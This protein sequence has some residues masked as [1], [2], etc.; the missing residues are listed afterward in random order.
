MHSRRQDRWRHSRDARLGRLQSD[1]IF[2]RVHA[3]IGRFVTRCCEQRQWRENTVRR[4]LHRWKY[5]INSKR[6]HHH[7]FEYVVRLLFLS[8]WYTWAR[9]H[10]LP[11]KTYNSIVV[12]FRRNNRHNSFAVLHALPRVHTQSGSGRRDHCRCRVYGRVARRQTD[13]ANEKYIFSSL[14]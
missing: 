4:H 10:R 14:H 11:T 13:V 2:C 1:F 12:F 9:E 6:T 7:A 3:H 5:I 8:Y